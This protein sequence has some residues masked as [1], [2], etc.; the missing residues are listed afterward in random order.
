[1]ISREIGKIARSLDSIANYEFRDIDLSKGQ[2]LYLVRI[3]EQPGLIQEELSDIL[4]VDRSTVARA[5]RKLELNGLVKRVLSETNRKNKPLF[6]TKKGEEL[7]CFVL[8]EHAYSE[9]QL[10]SALTPE[11]A[12]CLYRLLLKAGEAIVSDWERVKNGKKRIY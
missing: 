12:D 10:C 7:A 6:A 3:Y 5:V 1:M 9:Q 11:E 4:K 8:R 2:Y